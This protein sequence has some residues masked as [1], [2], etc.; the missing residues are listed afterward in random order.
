MPEQFRFKQIFR[1]SA[2]VDGDEWMV[3]TITVK[4]QAA[5]DQLLPCSA[6]SLNQ[7]GAVGIGDLVN[8][9]IDLLHLRLVP[10]MFSNLYLFLSSFRR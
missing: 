10:M 3:L 2:A 1:E 7:Y 6:L 8:E 9:T 5:R 4:M